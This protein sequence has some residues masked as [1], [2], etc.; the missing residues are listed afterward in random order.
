MKDLPFDLMGLAAE[1]V[2]TLEAT[3]QLLKGKFSTSG[4]SDVHFPVEKFDLFSSGNDIKVGG[5]LSLNTEGNFYLVF[6]RISYS[7]YS[8]YGIARN[9]Y[10]KY[11]VWAY[12]KTNKDYGRALIRYKTLNDRILGLIHPC[13]LNFKDDKHFDH[14]FYVVCNDEQKALSAMNW[15]FRNAVMEMGEGMMLETVDKDIIIG[16]NINFDPHNTVEIAEF[17]SKIASLQ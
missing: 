9:D 10:D 3:Y 2:Q 1:D 6:L 13:E 17:A 16:S 7:S 5:I 12:I 14:Q 4:P 11:K 15:N 8:T